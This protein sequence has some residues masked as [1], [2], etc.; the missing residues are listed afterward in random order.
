MPLN[1][2]DKEFIENAIDRAILRSRVEN[3]AAIVTAKEA[4]S[5][6]INGRFDHCPYPALL[7]REM[8]IGWLKLLLAML[9]SGAI[10]GLSSDI[11][12]FIAALVK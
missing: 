6:E 4:A 1:T 2:S 3:A 11:P 8:K 5:K 10:G 9:V 12:K 7:R